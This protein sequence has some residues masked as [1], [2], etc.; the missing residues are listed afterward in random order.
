MLPKAQRVHQDQDIKRLIQTGKTFFLPQLTIKYLTNKEGLTKVGFIV[1]TKVDKSAVVR[2]QLTRHL[3]EA[4]RTLLKDLKPG[5][6]LLIIAKKSA[7]TLSFQELVGQLVFAFS[8]MK[9]YNKK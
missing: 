5:Y 1:S 3:R 8:Q 2:H 6:S 9:I 7:L 4:S